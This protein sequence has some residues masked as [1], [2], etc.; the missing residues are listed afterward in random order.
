MAFLKKDEL[1]TVADIELIDILAG[2]DNSDAVVAE[3]IEESIDTMKG[4][5]S[6]FY[7]IE[8]IF[9]ATGNERKKSILKRLKDIVIYEIYERHSRETNA[10]AAR[11]YNEAMDW[12]EKSYTGELGDRTLPPRPT[13]KTDTEG[14]TGDV[15]FGGNTKYDSKY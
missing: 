4:F 7:D 15:L 11:R 5:L 3:I 1:V 6:R 10:V 13:E 14:T 8:T 9:G 2:I 12:L